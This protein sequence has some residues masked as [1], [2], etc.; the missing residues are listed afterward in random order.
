[1]GATERLLRFGPFEL[2]LD[3]EELRR[4]GLPIKLSP[5]PFAI[6]AMLAGRSGQVVTREEI[7]KEVWGEGTFVDFEHGLNQ[8]IK[9]IRTVLNDNADQP[10]YVETI[11]RRG[12]RF[13]APVVSKTIAAPPPKV[14]ESKSGIQPFPPMAPV[15]EQVPAPRAAVPPV[16]QTGA[17]TPL[18]LEPASLAGK[19]VSHYRVL[20]IIGGGGMG[21]VYKAEDLKL[22]RAVALKF[23]P[24]E[25]RDDPLALQQLER[26]ARAASVLD[27]PNICSIYEFGEHEGRPFIVMQ[28][29]E[30]QTVRELLGAAG[31]NGVGG[32]PLP[33]NQLLDLAIQVTAGLEAAHEKGI[34]HRDIKPANLFVT[35]KGVAKILDFG[36]AK[37]VRS[38]ERDLS[39]GRVA[40]TSDDPG[41]VPPPPLPAATHPLVSRDTS[42]TGTVAYMSPEQVRGEPLD[43]R[44]DLFS[45][46]LVLYQMATGQQAFRSD[47]AEGMRN[48][49]LNSTP[50][51]P[52]Q[53]NP[54][55]PNE[56][57]AVIQKSME[58]DRELRYQHAS[59]IRTDLEKVRQ[60]QQE[61]QPRR[62]RR[63][64]A[65][66]VAAIVVVAGGILYWR[67]Q[68][69]VAL[70]EKDT[71]VLADFA[72][73]TGDAVFDDTLKQAVSVDL[74]QS[75]FLNL[76]SDRSVNDTL[77]LMGRP[78]GAAVTVDTAREVCLRTG[79]KAVLGGYISK[80]GT[81][82]VVGLEAVACQSGD[83]LAKSQAEAKKKEDVL[84]ALDKATNS[85]R[86]DLG[87]SLASVQKFDV[88][89]A[90]ATTSSLD[91]LKAYSLGLK[92]RNTQ[93]SEAAI[94]FM[95]QAIELDP[96]F[97]LA[98]ARLAALYSNLSQPGLSAENAA[99]AYQLRNLVSEREKLLIAALYY[100]KVLGDLNQAREA[101]LLLKQT[102]PRELPAYTQLT[103]IYT[104][105]GKHEQALA[106]A[107]AG[108][109]MDPASS[110]SYYNLASAYMNLNRFADAHRV[111]KQAESHGVSRESLLPVYY[112]LA[113][114]RG[115][116]EDMARQLAASVGK[117]ST[118]TDLLKMQSDTEAYYGRLA[119][120]REFSRLACSANVSGRELET[121]ALCHVDAALQEAELG[122]SRRA[123]EEAQRALQGSRETSYVVQIQAALAL[124]RAGEPAQAL[125]LA[126]AQGKQFPSHTVLNSYWIP[127]VRAAAAIA[128]KKPEAAIEAL[129]PATVYELGS[130]SSG[131]AYLYPVYLR[132]LAYLQMGDGNKAAA[133]FQK[134]L[135][136]Q[137]VI[138]S[139]P[140]AALAR[141]QLARAQAMMGDT[142]A[143]RKSYA[144]FLSLWKDA[145]PDNAILKQAK[146]EY[147][148]LQ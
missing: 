103:A 98:Y 64:W 53:I 50:T 146:S 78:Q 143:A 96:N 79:S 14:V 61:A 129:Q 120:A 109:Q 6:M 74:G 35:K 82:Y 34:I 125:L 43:A 85:I 119:K 58:R 30:G 141:L 40:A 117:P 122:D 41:R 38:G 1:M 4:D 56:L 20:N 94:P 106:E 99:K 69:A 80:L 59:E 107:E 133:E 124:A 121:V 60:E 134:M 76:V 105:L 131:V 130:P 114:W 66:I 95:T 102:Y 10:K 148:R 48:A 137:G 142:A 28:L 75:P 46:G 88:P 108:L 52:Q 113:F 132:G 87:E 24:E 77:R 116:K 19:T 86:R 7:Q 135:D 9:Q 13:L 25:V 33:I 111:I 39:H 5:Q 11:P 115:D 92:V 81:E 37:T 91:A 8:C 101:N 23:L 15:A 3:A 57:Q 138:G 29:L 22:P 2:N 49:I 31:G 147:A 145:D 21:V 72:N 44:T 62:R 16:E 47:S 12:Y 126:E 118:Q 17:A 54:A 45:F 36:L 144:D 93:G 67:S 32:K 65:A 139:S 127:T 100:S 90:Q 73:S 140:T 104:A 112:E 51:A 70:T 97:A 71:I 42:I 27:H 128:Q 110:V 89:L 83:T 136:H 84:K 123:K 26:E 63:T 68:R 18:Q 55:V